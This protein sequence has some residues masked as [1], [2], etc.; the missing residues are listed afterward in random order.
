[1]RST[2]TGG[3][4][5]KYMPDGTTKTYAIHPAI[6]VARMGNADIDLKDPSSY[7]IGAETPY[8][9][10]NEGQPYKK[11][12]K[13]K[14]QAQRFR[15]F[16]Y[17]DGVAIRE[18][19][20]SHPDVAAITWT[21]QLGN[22]KAALDISD[23]SAGTISS[24]VHRPP[25]FHPSATRNAHVKDKDPKTQEKLRAA[26][27]MDT[28]NQVVSAG[29]GLVDMT[30][31][32]TMY[33]N[34]ALKPV[35][36]EVKLASLFCDPATGHLLAFASDGLSQGLADDKFSQ[37]A[38]LGVNSGDF[39]NN[40]NWYDQTGDGPVTAEIKFADGS[41]V[42][43]DQPEQRAWLLCGLPKYA[44]GFNYF[45]NLQHIA[46]GALF[47]NG[48]AP[49]PS[50]AKDIFPILRSVS[51]L[52]WVS[53]RGSLG[54][55]TNR[56]GFYLAQQRLKLLSDN[57]PDPKGQPY[58]ARH[59]VFKRIRNPNTLPPRPT[60]KSKVQPPAAVEPRGMPQVPGD[61]LRS[62]DKLNEHDW[63]LPYVTTLQY[64]MLE[65]WRDGDF[66]PDPDGVYDFKPLDKYDIAD[67]PAALDRAAVDGTCGTPFYPGIESWNVMQ[68]TA[69]YAAPMRIS[70]DV[71]P[72][73]L[74]MGNA[75]PWQSDYM[76]C[77]D[78]WWPVQRPNHV[79]RDGQVLQPWAPPEWFADGK[80]QYD[81]MV[82]HWWR[83]GFVTTQNSGATYEEQE[84]NL[85]EP[86]T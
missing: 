56:G 18:I 47:K 6:G 21:V 75:L 86:S 43:L 1:M 2:A 31:Y 72:G 42:T 27:C 44:P 41:T 28:G 63:A 50:F 16:E 66:D 32:V 81:Q 15:I 67:Q 36:T 51:Q 69:L 60:D 84:R 62:I 52:Q 4:G 10:A 76:D 23:S 48:A 74:T 8:Q 65:K 17:Q 85:E 13:L 55:G 53:D 11:A 29:D 19:A 73:D 64:A 33:A 57:D 82:Q 37:T 71:R 61:V 49:R 46:Q 5:G 83:L 7:Y 34:D 24:P 79:T 54:H 30:S 59:G 12:G 78:G 14:K 77:N 26:M 39:A 35:T 68:L 40:D 9:T 70:A 38:P 45:T 20:Q 80:E 58:M 25:D 22:R 3:A